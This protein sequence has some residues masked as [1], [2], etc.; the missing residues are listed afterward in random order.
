MGATGIPT[1]SQIQSWDTQHLEAA[2]DHWEA[3]AQNWQDAF[4]AVYKQVPAPGGVPW[5]GRA[6]DAALLHVGG[7]RLQ[8]VGAADTLYG[9][10]ATARAGAYE[11]ES[12]KQTAL[13]TVQAA[14]DQGFMVGEDL[15]VVDRSPQ[16]SAILAAQR[17]A[18]AQAHSAAIRG[19]AADLASTDGA[20]AGQVTTAAAGLKEAAFKDG[21]SSSPDGTPS[22]PL[23]QIVGDPKPK[24]GGGGIQMVDNTTGPQPPTPTPGAQPQIGPFPVPPGIGD[25]LPPAP[26]VPKDPTG[27]LLTPQNLPPAPPPPNIP[28]VKPAPPPGQPPMMGP[29]PTAPLPSF[30]DLVN[31]VRQ[32][33]Q[34]LDQQAAAAARPTPG[35]LG[36]AVVGGCTSTGIIAGIAGAETGPIDGPIAV[37]GC[38][39]GG[40][41]GLGTYLTGLWANN[42]F[43]GAG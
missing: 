2:A 30:P 29:P 24:P 27:G 23:D 5:E 26:T 40:L 8:A 39:L 4:T 35:G 21:A 42:A 11:I 10:A 34:Q 33:Q 43:G 37:G 1:L 25:N 36:A 32:Q 12:A 18:Q 38:V 31:Q 16:R 6:A 19:A 41:G 20:V 17:Q 22:S 14:K 9:S 3:R 7:D 15:S 13:Q 28:G